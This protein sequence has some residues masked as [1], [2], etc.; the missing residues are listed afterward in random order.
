MSDTNRDDLAAA[1][2]RASDL[3]PEAG[4]YRD[5]LEAARARVSNLEREAEELRKRNA[6]LE[7]PAP[8]PQPSKMAKAMTTATKWSLIAALVAVAGPSRF[9]NSHYT[10][11][12]TVALIFLGIAL[13]CWCC[14]G[15]R[16]PWA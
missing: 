11:H 2:A 4:P 14:S 13:V 16:R 12:P 9:G 3:D 1:P 8:A 15:F 6:E 10:P 5:D 7:R